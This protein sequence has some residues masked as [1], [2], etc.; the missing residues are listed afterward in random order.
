MQQPENKLVT[1][2]SLVVDAILVIAFF[3]YMYTVVSTH[4]PSKDH[5]MIL[6]FGAS[7]SACLTLVFWLTL[8]MVRV[9]VRFQRAESKGGN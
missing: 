5:R 4:V 1:P 8:Q 3:I 7:C 6:F 2:A 9:V